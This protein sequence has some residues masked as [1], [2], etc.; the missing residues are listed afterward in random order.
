MQIFITCPQIYILLL[1]N[2]ITDAAT[3]NS[4]GYYNSY[5]PFPRKDSFCTSSTY[6]Y[7]PGSK[8]CQ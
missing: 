2:A 4:I 3:G 1:L 8:L 6:D 7:D 5:N